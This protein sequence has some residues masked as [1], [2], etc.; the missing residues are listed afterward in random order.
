MTIGY[1]D[2]CEAKTRETMRALFALLL[3]EVAEKHGG[4]TLKA[5]IPQWCLQ[6]WP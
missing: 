5:N 6:R 1:R 3:V 4:T 2:V